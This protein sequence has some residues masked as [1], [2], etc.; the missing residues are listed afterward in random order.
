M[1]T[2]DL[3]PGA[4]LDNGRY[5]VL[6]RAGGG[7]F[8]TVYE[9]ED[10][11]SPHKA[12]VAIKK[13]RFDDPGFRAR[14]KSEA[15]ILAELDHQR[16]VPFVR[17]FEESGE[18]HLVMKYVAG[19]NLKDAMKDSPGDFTVGKKV[20]ILISVLKALDYLS[21]RNPPVVQRDI[22]PSN[23]LIDTNKDA[24]LADFG[25]ARA[26][27]DP[28]LTGAGFPL[29]SRPFMAPELFSLTQ[30]QLPPP[31]SGLSASSA[32]GCLVRS[33]ARTR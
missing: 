25:I 21:T 14:L 2:E 33:F 20:E 16:I 15:K 26:A 23:I 3:K 24:W 11:S 32:G 19:S 28:R 13:V 1:A 31:M 7:G 12:K 17:T 27:G 5:K 6:R 29:G 22:K 10:T 8:G 4:L 9:V 18:L 30:N